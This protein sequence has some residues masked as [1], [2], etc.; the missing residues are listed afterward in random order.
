MAAIV[1]AKASV[2]WAAEALVIEH[3]EGVKADTALVVELS[4]VRDMAAT[5]L[6]LR[7]LADET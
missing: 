4:A 2:E 6:S 3:C 5:D 7:L 1:A